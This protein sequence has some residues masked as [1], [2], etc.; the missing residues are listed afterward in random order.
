MEHLLTQEQAAIAWAT[1]AG[2]LVAM[3]VLRRP[4]LEIVSWFLVGQVSSFYWVVPIAMAMG[5]AM[6]HEPIG[7]FWG[8]FGMFVWTGFAAI[9][10]K[11]STDPIGTIQT[12]WR[13]RQGQ[14]ES[15]R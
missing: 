12:L 9:F 4:W 15:E 2:W 14:G 5:W 6:Y 11:L 7:F 8:A 1:G 3:I 13:L 10:T